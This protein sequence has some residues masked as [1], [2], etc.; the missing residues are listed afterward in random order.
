MTEVKKEE[1][2]KK[3]SA[4]EFGKMVVREGVN[5]IVGMFFG[6]LR[7]MQVNDFLFRE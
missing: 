4:K 1:A 6:H 3:P 5:F 2:K 7:A